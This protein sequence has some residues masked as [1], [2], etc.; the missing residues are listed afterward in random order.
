MHLPGVLSVFT[1][2]GMDI[3]G[4]G[5][6]AFFFPLDWRC[7]DFKLRVHFQSKEFSVQHVAILIIFRS[8]CGRDAIR[9]KTISSLRQSHKHALWHLHP[10]HFKW[11]FTVTH[12]W[13]LVHNCRQMPTA[14]SI[15]CTDTH[16]CCNCSWSDTSHCKNQTKWNQHCSAEI[17][18]VEAQKC[19]IHCFLLEWVHHGIS[20]C[21]ACNTVFSDL[22]KEHSEA[23]LKNS[24][25]SRDNIFQPH[26]FTKLSLKKKQ[27][28]H[29]AAYYF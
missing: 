10:T 18:L 5:C 16:N 25:C 2:S 17:L 11:G 3:A 15:V 4:K 14:D 8:G 23:L 21:H 29:K 9:N 1:Y 12:W 24:L 26:L 6:I 27:L 19:T 13:R 20:F 22:I 28:E 7:W